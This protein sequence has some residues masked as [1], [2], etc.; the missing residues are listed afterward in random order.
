LHGI[1]LVDSKTKRFYVF[2]LAAGSDGKLGAA[3]AGSALLPQ[4]GDRE[5][6]NPSAIGVSPD[7]SVVV[8]GR[9]SSRVE[10]YR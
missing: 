3:L 8:A 6:K 1:Y 5:M 10:R 9:S 4:E 7:G 2:H